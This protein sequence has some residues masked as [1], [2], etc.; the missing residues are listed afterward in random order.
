MD[1]LHE[2]ALAIA[3]H[4]V[5]SEIELYA[6]HVPADDG[7]SMY[8]IDQPS[9]AEGS[10][11]D[12][13]AIVDQAIEYINAR[14]DEL[15]YE[16]R[17]QGFAV[18]F[19]EREA[20]A[21]LLP[22][23]EAPM[24]P[25]CW[26]AHGNPCCESIDDDMSCAQGSPEWQDGFNCGFALGKKTAPAADPMAQGEQYALVI[27]D[28]ITF[29]ENHWYR[30]YRV[31]DVTF[32]APIDRQDKTLHILSLAA[33]PRVPDGWVLVP[34]EPTPK[35]VDATWEHIQD[36]ERSDVPESQGSRNKRI[37]IA[38]IAAAPQPKEAKS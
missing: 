20:V 6:K 25:R 12:W 28:T 31:D 14:G 7:S 21:H 27:G 8:R 33:Q 36:K 11:E 19:V 18:W 32:L 1:R 26:D 29:G 15:P 30:R 22:K 38:M 16:M 23:S 2:L 3:D 24:E 35:M 9:I 34:R 13:S 37:Y 5:R 4:S 17:Q 10:A